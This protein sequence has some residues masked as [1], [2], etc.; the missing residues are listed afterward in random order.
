MSVV[1]ASIVG[2]PFIDACLQSLYA[3]QDPA[4][5]EVIVVDCRGAE[6]AARLRRHFPAARIIESARRESVPCLRRMGAEA[7]RAPVVAIVEEHCAAGPGWLNAIAR[8]MQAGD[9]AVGGPILDDNYPRLRDWVTYFIEYGA[10]LPPW[11]DGPTS[12]VN[13]ANAAY[14]RDLLLANRDRLDA[15]YWEATL[16]PKLLADGHR[17]RA[18]SA[19]VMRH[20]GPFDFGYYLRQRYLFSRA[21]A[22]ARRGSV[23]RSVRLAYLAAAPVVPLLLLARLIAR[24]FQKRCHPVRF[25]QSL[26][27]VFVALVVY[28]AGEWMGYA[29]GPGRALSEVE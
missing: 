11:P 22:G 10:S 19:M 20:R 27:M 29:W 7:A 12:F 8:S 13:G 26:P 18:V 17:F 25:A 28:V 9:A 24:V 3:Q 2:P 1:V 15:G 4:P 14:R 16:S 21:F 23:A 6:H 5:F